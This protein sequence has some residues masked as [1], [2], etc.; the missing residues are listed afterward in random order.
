M[1]FEFYVTVE[2]TKQGRFKGESVR[3]TG[4]RVKV[5]GMPSSLRASP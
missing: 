5:P 2:G 1:A 4:Q 3:D